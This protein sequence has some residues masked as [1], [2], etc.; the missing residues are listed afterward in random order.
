MNIILYSMAVSLISNQVL[1]VVTNWFNLHICSLFRV[2]L[3]PII[4][5]THSARIVSING[6]LLAVILWGVHYIQHYKGREMGDETLVTHLTALRDNFILEQSITPCRGGAKSPATIQSKT[7]RASYKALSG[8]R[9]FY[10]GKKTLQILATL[11]HISFA[12]LYSVVTGLG[13]TFG[14]QSGTEFELVTFG[15]LITYIMLNG[16][17]AL[18]S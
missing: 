3:I 2:G 9:I 16:Y 11:W 7:S 5:P 1:K 12:V 18:S 6:H 10:K 4:W 14:W 15:R 8:P 13:I 17:L